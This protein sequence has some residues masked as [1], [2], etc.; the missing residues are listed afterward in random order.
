MRFSQ[1]S[2]HCRN[3]ATRRRK[4]WVDSTRAAPGDLASLG[5]VF[6]CV[7]HLAT[8]VLSVAF[9]C[10]ASNSVPTSVHGRH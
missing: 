8:L 4:S 2:G 10:V 6:L 5:G 7:V 9:V 1:G 3:A